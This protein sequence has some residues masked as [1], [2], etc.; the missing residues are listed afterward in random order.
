V[1][2]WQGI[3]PGISKVGW[4]WAHLSEGQG[5]SCIKEICRAAKPM[6]A[7]ETRVFLVFCQI[8]SLPKKIQQASAYRQTDFCHFPAENDPQ[9][10]LRARS[11]PP[12]RAQARR[13]RL[14]AF[15]TRVMERHPGM[16]YTMVA[17]LISE[18]ELVA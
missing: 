1:T 9:D 12:P 18:M 6:A 10:A 11:A 7:V 8:C 13:C 3:K 4:G 14:A 15:S 2:A 17:V 5:T 16:R